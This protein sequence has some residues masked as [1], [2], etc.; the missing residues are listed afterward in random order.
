MAYFAN[1]SS[2]EAFDAQCEDCPLG[3]GWH[4]PCQGDLIEDEREPKPCPIALVQLTYNYD[5]LKD[6]N[7]QLR[8]AMSLL[9]AD[10]GE[11]QVRKL[12]AEDCNR[13]GDRVEMGPP[14]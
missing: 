14:E 4:D 6:G 7:K 2:G 10:D 3:Y 13:T 8:E 12:L 1:G 11:C 9:V 5:Q